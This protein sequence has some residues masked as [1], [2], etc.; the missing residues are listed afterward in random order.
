MQEIQ[1]PPQ[2]YSSRRETQRHII[3]R[4]NKVEM[5][6]KMLSVARKVGLPT[7][8]SPSDSQ[9][10]SCQKLYKSEEEE[11]ILNIVKEKK[12]QSIPNVIS[13]QT[14][15]HKQRRNRILYRQAN[16]ERFCHH[17]ACLARAP[18]GRT[19]Y[20]KEKVPATAKTYQIVM[21]IDTMKKLH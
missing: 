2:R 1:R 7:K 5:M 17:Q 19:K 16:A 10:I 13:S 4:L 14:K 12:F 15:L 21:T 20:G 3:V 18:E 8:R 6:E 9:Q 11:P